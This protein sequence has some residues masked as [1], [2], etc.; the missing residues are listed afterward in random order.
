MI[1][2]H[3]EKCGLFSDFR[4]RFRS[5]CSTADLLTIVSYRIARDFN[6]SWTTRAV[7]VYTSKAFDGV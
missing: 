2:D 5:S 6:R 4:Y 7:A 3:L 1:A